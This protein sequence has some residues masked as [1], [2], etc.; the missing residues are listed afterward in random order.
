MTGRIGA[1]LL[2]VASVD[3]GGVAVGE[4]VLS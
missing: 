2:P 4:D 3:D 1:Q